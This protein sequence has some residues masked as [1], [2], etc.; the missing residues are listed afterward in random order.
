[1][2]DR[3]LRKLWI[4]DRLFKETSDSR[5]DLN[6]EHSIPSDYIALEHEVEEKFNLWLFTG[7]DS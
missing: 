5:I 6:L 3:T 7:T 4:R 2:G 1:M